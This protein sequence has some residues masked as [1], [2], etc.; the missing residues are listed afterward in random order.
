MKT[1]P[2]PLIV[3]QT[4]D[5]LKDLFDA[6]RIAPSYELKV[7][8]M[9]IWL[10][11]IGFELAISPG[12]DGYS[13]DGKGSQGI[14]E[15]IVLQGDGTQARI[16]VPQ[17]IY[18]K[19]VRGGIAVLTEAAFLPAGDLTTMGLTLDEIDTLAGVIIDSGLREKID[20][21]LWPEWLKVKPGKEDMA[22][23]ID[24]PEKP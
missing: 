13:Q 4:D 22:E 8:T 14:P 23:I 7:R 6:L 9:G 11:T 10:G 18:D 2:K 5:Q 21:S 20:P 1:M 15:P 17:L 3:V 24:F 12:V 19:L 16:E